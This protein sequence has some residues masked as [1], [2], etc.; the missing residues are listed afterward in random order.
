MTT[1]QVNAIDQTVHRWGEDGQGDY[2][3]SKGGFE[4]GTYPTLDA[5]KAAIDEH[6]GYELHPDDY[7]DDYI[8]ATQI[9]D[10]DAYAD[11]NGDYIVDYI[12]C[13]DKIDRVSFNAALEANS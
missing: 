11:P 7:Q 8:S 5:A 10:A 4:I 13:V 1:Y 2:V 9:E 6:F 3:C 12:L